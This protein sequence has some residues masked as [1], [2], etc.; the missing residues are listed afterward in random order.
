MKEKIHPT[1]YEEAE[2]TCLSCGTVWTLGA[3]YAEKRVD[4]CSNCHPFYT[5][6]QRIVDTEGQVD[7][8]MKRLQERDRRQAE[9]EEADAEPAG[10]DENASL[11]ALEVGKRYVQAMTDDGLNTIGDVMNRLNEEGDEGLTRISGVGRKVLSDVKKQLRNLGF[12]VPD[13][14]LD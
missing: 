3:T 5:G 1:W 8:F 7:R 14:E 2:I 10:P 6:E 9:R 13:V 4:I 11:E 12:D